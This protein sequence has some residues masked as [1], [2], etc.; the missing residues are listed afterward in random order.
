MLRD[1]LF[2]FAVSTSSA[3]AEAV[4]QWNLGS[5]LAFQVKVVGAARSSLPRAALCCLGAEP[6]AAVKT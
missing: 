2:W 4:V 5:N 3:P 1:L 6:G